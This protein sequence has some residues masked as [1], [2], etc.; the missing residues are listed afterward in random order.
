MWWCGKMRQ[1][2]LS[3]TLLC[4]LAS[5]GFSPIYATD[6]H[7]PEGSPAIAEHLRA[8]VLKQSSGMQGQQLENAIA[9]TINPT[10]EKS[11]LGDAYRLEFN[12]KQTKSAAIVEQDGSIARYQIGL[13]S[14]YKLIDAASGDVLNRG[15]IR[16]VASFNVADE[17]FAAYVAEKD[18]IQNALKE[19]S[20][21]YGQR[22]AAQFAAVR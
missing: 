15:E 14:T 12:L 2:V 17:K 10:S 1:L 19:I 7:R 18:A 21:D 11:S 4:L 5:C 20:A 13:T 9:D 6:S 8:I 16:R 3:L 22:L